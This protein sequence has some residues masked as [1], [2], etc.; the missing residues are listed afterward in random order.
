MNVFFHDFVLI[1]LF[2]I[3]VFVVCIFYFRMRNTRVLKRKNSLEVYLMVFPIF[4]LF[5]LRVPSM[6]LLQNKGGEFAGSQDVYVDAS[7]WF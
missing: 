4:F 7:Q 2:F 6:L 5:V 3:T 1:G